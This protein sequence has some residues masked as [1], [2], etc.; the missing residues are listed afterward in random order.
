VAIGGITEN[1]IMDLSGS[2]IAGVALVSSIFAQKN[3]GVSVSRLLSLTEKILE[4]D[5]GD[6]R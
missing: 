2:G 4:S 5:Q 1:N 3:I 6:A